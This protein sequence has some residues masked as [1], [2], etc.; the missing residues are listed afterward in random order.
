MRSARL[1]ANPVRASGES[2]TFPRWVTS[3]SCVF[4]TY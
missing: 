4:V 3:G 2:Q 1:P